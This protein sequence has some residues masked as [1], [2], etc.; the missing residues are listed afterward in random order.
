MRSNS[1]NFTH[2]FLRKIESFEQDSI[3]LIAQSQSHTYGEL[4][5]STRN[6][7][8]LLND[9]KANSVIGIIGDYDL[10]TLAFFLACVEKGFIVTPLSASLAPKDSIFS[11]MLQ[12][13][14]KEGQIDYL[15]YNNTLHSTHSTDKKHSIIAS[16]QANHTSGLILFSSGST[17]KPK[18]IVHNLNTLLQGFLEKKP[19]RINIL[20][21]LMFDHIGGLNTLFNVLSLGAC[22]ITLKNRKDMQ[23]IAKSIQDYKIALLPA[24]P[25][26]LHLFLLSNPTQLY[27]LSSLRLITY[28]TEK[29][30]D[31]LLTKLKN[32]FPKVRFHQTFGASEIGI[33]QTTTKDNFIRLDNM[34]YKIVN[35]ELFIK[36]HTNALGYLNSDNSVFDDKGYFATGDLVETKFINGEE[37]IKII[38]RA[39]EVINVGGEKVIP[40]EVEGVL[41]QIPFIND[42]VVY[43]ESNAITGQSVSVKVVLDS[44]KIEVVEFKSH[45]NSNLMLKKHIRTFCKDKLA[46]FKIPS[47]VSIVESLEMSER[48]KK[49]R[50]TNGGGGNTL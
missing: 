28:G 25:S 35:N 47:K 13:C 42:C 20:L 19:K 4:L 22:G 46:P 14:I 44:E 17:G 11:P 38:G 49:L 26:L 1:Y 21:F 16:L 10:K 50:L 32:A 27:D 30:S 48:F 12:S 33:T 31:S 9:I 40:Q 43:G 7:L 39:K 8:N 36:S 45:T 3:C 23:E 37:Y 24:S 29:M 15:F 34:E 6:A 5:D 18:A 2:P 41:L